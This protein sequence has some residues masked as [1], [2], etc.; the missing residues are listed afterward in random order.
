MNFFGMGFGADFQNLGGHITVSRAVFQMTSLK[1][2]VQT[3]INLVVMFNPLE[4]RVKRREANISCPLGG[5]VGRGHVVQQSPEHPVLKAEI[6]QPGRVRFLH[7]KYPS[8]APKKRKPHKIHCF[9]KY[10]M[11]KNGFCFVFRMKNNLPGCF[12]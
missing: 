6:Q 11:D 3:C 9:F 4:S 12:S 10:K 1:T 7:P 2:R 8:M 5:L